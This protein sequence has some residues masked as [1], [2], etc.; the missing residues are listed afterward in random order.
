MLIHIRA[1]QNSFGDNLV[2]TIFNIHESWSSSPVLIKQGVSQV[3]VTVHNI[4]Y[5][6]YWQNIL[7]G[8]SH[9]SSGS[10]AKQKGKSHRHFYSKSKGYTNAIAAND[11][12]AGFGPGFGPGTVNVFRNMIEK[13][14][15]YKKIILRITWT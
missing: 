15:K 14:N 10:Y 12:C 5:T 2:I 6:K 11:H 9:Q 3:L 1:S 7:I 4:C 8:I 13:K